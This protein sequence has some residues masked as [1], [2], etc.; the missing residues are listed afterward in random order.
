MSEK[1]TRGKTISKIIIALVAAIIM[2]IILNCIQTSINYPNGKA[3]VYIAKE[4][5]KEGQILDSNLFEEEIIDSRYKTEST[6]TDVSTII[7]KT[8]KDKIEKGSI[9]KENFDSTDELVK[10]FISPVEIS[11]NTNDISYSVAGTVLSG[12]KINIYC[13]DQATKE[14]VKVL[15]NVYVNKSFASDGTTNL[16]ESSTLFTVILEKEDASKISNAIARGQI[17]IEKNL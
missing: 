6:V 4:D 2:F 11:I 12:D 5:I 16:G 9:L 10:T 13:I 17:V 15:E 7:G 1:K 3:T 8:A 14:S